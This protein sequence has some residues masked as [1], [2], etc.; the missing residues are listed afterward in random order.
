MKR[1]I[2][3][4]YVNQYRSGWCSSCGED[5]GGESKL[6]RSRR[7]RI[8]RTMRRVRRNESRRAKKQAVVLKDVMFALN[9]DANKFVAAVNEMAN[10]VSRK[11]R[12]FFDG[13]EMRSLGN[14]EK[15]VFTGIHN[16]SGIEIDA[17][18]S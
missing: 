2:E 13:V 9:F 5:H 14:L 7:L 17:A 15:K 18:K 1:R 3:K 8:E 4:K 16:E 6:E 10:N 12:E 11:L